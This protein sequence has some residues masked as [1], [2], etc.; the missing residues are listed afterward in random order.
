MNSRFIVRV[1]RRSRQ[2]FLMLGL[3]A[4]AAVAQDSAAT[5]PDR[6][7]QF[8][9]GARV[10]VSTPGTRHVGRLV[11]LTDTTV[12]VE[13]GFPSLYRFLAADA[14]IDRRAI[15][16]VE[17]STTAKQRKVATALGV[18]SGAA[19]GAILGMASVHNPCTDASSTIGPC[20]NRG[21]GALFG[22]A[23][24]AGVGWLVGRYVFGRDRWE[25][26]SAVPPT[27]PPPP[28]SPGRSSPLPM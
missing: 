15:T 3:A 18:A 27:P 25:P 12:V 9:P 22:A 6:S 23:I 26:V 17:I 21:H 13:P 1:A 24:G 28:P 5:H 16:Q 20:F 14:H 4:P 2:G 10:R 11:R 19:T 7:N 8:I